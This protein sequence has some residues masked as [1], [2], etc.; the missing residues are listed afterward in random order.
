VV[1]D[2]F[3]DD[4]HAA[5][6]KADRDD[7]TVNTKNAL[8]DML[9]IFAPSPGGA[10]ES[11][12]SAVEKFDS[13]A[14]AA[15]T[16]AFSIFC[17]EGDDS[18]VGILKQSSGKRG[19]PSPGA[20]ILQRAKKPLQGLG[21]RKA[22]AALSETPPILAELPPSAVTEEAEGGDKGA[23]AGI[24]FQL[25]SDETEDLPP[26]PRRVESPLGFA[27]QRSPLAQMA[28]FEIFADEPEE[29]ETKKKAAPAAVSKSTGA[30]IFSV[31]DIY[32]DPHDESTCSTSSSLDG[33][34]FLSAAGQGRGARGMVS[35]DALRMSVSSS[36]SSAG[37]RASSDLFLSSDESP[38]VLQE[39]SRRR[40]KKRETCSPG[41]IDALLD[42]L[43][44]EDEE[45]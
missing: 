31:G 9:D 22:P 27:S 43:D 18:A 5:A 34:N 2:S 26:A 11:A 23:G 45:E 40:N 10:N 30:S 44:D 4:G 12:I 39:V 1:E 29:K 8:N 6:E 21:A 42:D 19:T 3:A 14:K 13:Q 35:D 41:G 25:Y 15:A 38:G 36:G 17:D 24:A 20:G 33:S 32:T 7:L 28:Q 37:G 16:P